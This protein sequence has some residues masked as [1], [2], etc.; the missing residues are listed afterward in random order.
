MSQSAK[1]AFV[2]LPLCLLHIVAFI[3]IFVGGLMV[4]TADMRFV[5]NVPI[6]GTVQNTPDK[7]AVVTLATTL[8]A[9]FTNP[10]LYVKPGSQSVADGMAEFVG[11]LTTMVIPLCIGLAIFSAPFFFFLAY[12]DGL[13]N[14][15]T[16]LAIGLYFLLSLVVPQLR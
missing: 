14:L 13:I 6:F 11:A 5:E 4:L 2:T 8:I 7:W 1:V 3:G 16:H 15:T 9:F 12:G 10:G